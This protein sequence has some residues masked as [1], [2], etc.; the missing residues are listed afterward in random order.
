MAQITGFHFTLKNQ[1]GDILGGT[2]DSDTQPMLILIGHG[3]ILPALELQ[4]KDLAVGARK[5]L[6]IS[7]AE[8]YGEVDKTLKMTLTRS[9][10]P[11]GTDITEGL[12]FDGGQRDGWPVIFRVVKIDGDDIYVDANHE[13][14]GMTLHYDVEITEKRDA[15]DEEI[16]HG[17]AH[18]AGGHQHQICIA[19]K[20]VYRAQLELKQDDYHDANSWIS[21]HIER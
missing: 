20:L 10:F 21:L 4:I 9:Q 5:E 17:H 12:R 18:G 14:A 16:A 2:R 13:L 11:E 7:A 6:I 15:S 8:A 3:N 1:F 19:A